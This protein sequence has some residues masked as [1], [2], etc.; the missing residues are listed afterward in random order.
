MVRRR[1]ARSPSLP[2]VT[3]KVRIG[4]PTPL[5]FLGDAIAKAAFAEALAQLSTQAD[6]TF[7]DVPLAPF[8]EIAQLLYGGPWVAERRLAI[9]GFFAAQPE[10]IDPT[11]RSVI[12]KADGK[13]AVDTFAALY[14]LEAGKRMADAVFAEIDLMLVP[15]TPTIH[16]RATVAADPI[17]R[18]SDFGLY[19]NF[20]NLLG[21]SALALPGPFRSDGLPAGITLLAPGGGDHRLA[22]FARRIEPLLHHTLGTTTAQPPRSKDS[23]PPLPS[24]E[25]MVQLA[26]VG[27][28]LSGMP[29][30]WQLLERSARLLKPART[31]ARYRLYALPGTVP[32]KPG[33]IQVDTGGT[34]IA[35]EIWEMPA[36]HFGSFVAL[37]PAPLGIGTL[38]LDDD[39]SVQ[40]FLCE[41][42]ATLD[43]E[44][45][46]CFGGWREFI[47]SRKARD[48]IH[49]Q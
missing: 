17:A 34:A 13:T 41:A 40:G 29:L 47:R 12:G 25:P 38:K 18:N 42:L 19:T 3:R 26:V 44:D 23:L 30:N 20:V 28:H 4:V 32:P 27:A 45:I 2:T 33:L 1:K 39:S 6:F 43:A 8:S 7:V 48:T 24:A 37:I 22:E 15:T 5:E 21:M 46:S 35:L 10:A 16:T 49:E 36:R 11:V 14:R 9:T 31:A